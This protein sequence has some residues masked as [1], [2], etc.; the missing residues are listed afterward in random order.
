[1]M[2]QWKVFTQKHQRSCSP[3]PARLAHLRAQLLAV[4]SRTAGSPPP[5]ASTAQRR[6]PAESASTG[7]GGPC[8]HG[9]ALLI[10]I[11]PLGHLCRGS[12]QGAAGRR[13]WTGSC[14]VLAALAALCC[15]E[16]AAST[17]LCCT[18]VAASTALCCTV[19]AATAALC[20]PGTMAAKLATCRRTAAQT[21]WRCV[22]A[23]G[24]H[25][26]DAKPAGI[27]PQPSVAGSTS[28]RMTQL[29]RQSEMTPWW[30]G[31]FARKTKPRWGI[32]S[33]SACAPA[34]LV[35]LTSQRLSS[36]ATSSLLLSP[37]PGTRHRSVSP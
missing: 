23:E 37:W 25:V 21:S 30:A 22:E 4:S 18:D 5:C 31:S 7:A 2:R 19:V 36:T 6:S 20:C 15:T 11:R 12:C 27:K 34:T 24:A 26:G 9:S 29:W 10:T 28:P 13:M 17:A 14:T 3:K 16:V 8:S 33:T 35:V 32:R 1:M